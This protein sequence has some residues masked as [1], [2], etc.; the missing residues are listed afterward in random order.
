MFENASGIDDLNAPDLLKVVYEPGK[1]ASKITKIV[2]A[3]PPGAEI[4]IKEM[5]SILQGKRGAYTLGDARPAKVYATGHIPS[6]IS[7]F[8]DDKETFLKSL[9]QDKSKLLVFYCGG[10]TCPF[11]GKAIEAATAAGYTNVKGFQA[12]IPAWKKAKLAVHVGPDW[13][14][15]NL[16]MHHVIIDVRE[17]YGQLDPAYQNSGIHARFRTGVDDETVHQGSNKPAVARRHR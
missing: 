15:K 17:P 9:P 16:D 2:F 11:T 1:A 8:P 4:D 6:A 3:L 14:V 12:G 5:V 13:L 10:P 7:T